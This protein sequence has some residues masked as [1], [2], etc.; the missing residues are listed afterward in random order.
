LVVRRLTLLWLV[1]AVLL[2]AGASPASL[3]WLPVEYWEAAARELGKP[4]DTID[5]VR[6]LLRNYV[7]VGL[8][9]AEVSADGTLSYATLAKGRE[10]LVLVR[11]GKELRPVKNLDPEIGRILPELSYFMTTGLGVMSRGLR[12]VLF[13]NI[14]D[15]GRPI[16]SGTRRGKLTGRYRTRDAEPVTVEWRAPLT[17]VAGPRRCPAGG[18]SL[19]ASWSYCPWHGVPSE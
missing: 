17:S 1:A 2:G 15:Q 4:G 19:E 3:W 10:S 11:D 8:V 14:D 6:K 12:L 16:L 7:V 13:P 18:E 5:R 9:D